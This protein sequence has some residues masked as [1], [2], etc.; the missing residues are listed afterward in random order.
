MARGGSDY[1]GG[2]GGGDNDP[3]GDENWGDD[4]MGD[5]EG[6]YDGGDSGDA[7]DAGDSGG[8]EGGGGGGGDEGGSEPAPAPAKE[9]AGPPK[10]EKE[11]WYAP[12]RDWFNG[13]GLGAIFNSIGNLGKEAADNVKAA[14][15]NP[16]AGKAPEQAAREAADKEMRKSGGGVAG[17]F[18]ANSGPQPGET[19]EQTRQR[20]FNE[21]EGADTAYNTTAKNTYGTYQTGRNALFDK[22][23]VETQTQM[24][25]VANL[26]TKALQ[27]ANDTNTVYTDLGS[28][29]TKAMD[30]AENNASNAMSLKDYMDPNNQVQTSVRKLYDDQAGNEAKRGQADYGVNAALSSQAVSQGM[31]NLGPMTVGQQLAIQ[32]QGQQKAADSY[33]LAQQRVQNLRDQGLAMGFKRSQESY[34][35]GQAAKDTA[36]RRRSERQ[37]TAA[38]LAKLMADFRA[39]EGGYDDKSGAL[40]NSKLARRMLGT[41]EDYGFTSG[42]ESSAL[43]RAQGIRGLR[44]SNADKLDALA[45]GQA[46]VN[47]QADAAEKARQ[48]SMWN[49]IINATPDMLSLFTT[50]NKKA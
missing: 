35:A 3:Y 33:A 50:K 29:Q 17:Q 9:Q 34:D 12:M 10:P 1:G 20:I 22:M 41:Q 26:K 43:Q 14:A 30:D 15:E 16:P 2:Y 6:G 11:P 36:A 23:D 38:E 31:S 8:Y 28:R 39:E 40:A 25:N 13:T 19:P 46:A 32:S 42:L 45:A 7:G 24:D 49:A 44:V 47:A 4:E 48:T 21:M 18:S 37:V 27:Q 5:E